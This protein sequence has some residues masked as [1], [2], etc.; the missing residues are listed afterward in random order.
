MAVKLDNMYVSCIKIFGSPIVPPLVSTFIVYK[1]WNTNG[2]LFKKI[3][4]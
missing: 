1:R 4:T 3:F 2:L